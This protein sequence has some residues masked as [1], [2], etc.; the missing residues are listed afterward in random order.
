MAV[1]EVGEVIWH[2][3]LVGK[4]EVGVVCESEGVAPGIPA[5]FLGT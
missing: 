4:V 2:G 1:D 3:G 5:F